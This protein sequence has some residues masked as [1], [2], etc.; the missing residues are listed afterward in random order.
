MQK[1]KYFLSI[2]ICLG[3]NIALSQENPW[4]SGRPDGH[5]PIS[6]MGD[7]YHGKGEWMLSYRYMPM[8][9]E[10]NLQSTDEIGN[11]TIY[12]SYMV[13]PQ[14]MQMNMHMVGIMYAPSDFI[15]LMGMGNFISNSMDL[16]TR[17]GAN[18]TTESG[19][20]GDLSLVSLLKIFN[21]NGQSLHV[22]LGVSIPTGDIDQRDDT[23][24]MENTQLAYP[25]QLGSGTWDPML[26]ITYLGQSDNFS[27]G[28]QP[29]YLFRLGDNS[30]NY[31]FG[32]RFD[33]VGWGALKL[34][35]YFS[36][37]TSLSYFNL[38]PIDGVDEDLNPTMMPLFD[39][40]NS[41]RSQID[42]GFGVNYY[43]PQGALKNIRLAAEVK[44]P[45]YQ[46]V[47]WIQMQ[48]IS[49]ATFGL[50]YTF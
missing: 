35:N 49:M 3:C 42:V 1:K 43:I 4:F 16:R 21:K 7:H 34:S 8:W 10:G 33:A 19:G 46:S 27:W 39:T 38:Q 22:N 26:G 47:N 32:N 28:L 44:L 6:V 18:F 40:V 5:A 20:F 36:F 30:E 2:L 50:Q 12:N 45:L 37:S 31:S 23:P 41:G 25:M 15:T 11:E 13:A 29:R 14:Q 24:M 48:N 17:M 9:M